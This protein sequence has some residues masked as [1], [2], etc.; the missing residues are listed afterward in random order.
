MEDISLLLQSVRKVNNGIRA[1]R[2]PDSTI[3][4]ALINFSTA[5]NDIPDGNPARA[6]E[7]S[8]A[9]HLINI[10]LGEDNPAIPAYLDFYRAAKA[11]E[12]YF[13]PQYINV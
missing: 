13:D 11:G 5:H 6:G 12:V 4:R 1:S 7:D 8:A 9:L 3:K 2:V 10:V